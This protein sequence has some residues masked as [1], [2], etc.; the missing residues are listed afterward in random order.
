MFVWRW[1]QCLA[2]VVMRGRVAM[3]GG[4]VTL[5]SADVGEAL[6]PTCSAA[7]RSDSGFAALR[8]SLMLCTSPFHGMSSDQHICVQKC[9]V[10]MSH[11]TPPF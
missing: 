11:Q 3:E 6:L 10:I 5:L 8:C 9:L 4:L 2:E 7:V 1:A